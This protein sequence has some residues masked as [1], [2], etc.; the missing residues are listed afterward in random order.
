[1]DITLGGLA[2]ALVA[3]AQVLA[4][5]A[6]REWIP[7]VSLPKGRTQLTAITM[8]ATAGAAVPNF[9]A[10]A[11]ADEATQQRFEIPGT[12]YEL[13]LNPAE[14]GPMTFVSPTLL[15]AIE[16]WLSRQFDLPIFNIHP[17]IELVTPERIANLRYRSLLSGV[18]SE[19]ASQLASVTRDTVAIYVDSERTIYLSNE[20]TGGKIAYLSVLVHELVH[21]AQN[22]AGLKYECAQEREKLAYSAQQRWLELFGRSLEQDFELDG[23]SLLPK[24]RCMN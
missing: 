4:V 22:L 11:A 15:A 13:L 16:N 19:R 12:G 10:P 23:F 3:I 7:P 2:F 9:S 1:M 21:H 8:L 6:C 14:E 24:T 20:W 17:R 18:A 5:I